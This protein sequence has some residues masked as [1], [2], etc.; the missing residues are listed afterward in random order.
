[1]KLAYMRKKANIYL[2]SGHVVVVQISSSFCVVI[3]TIVQNVKK[4]ISLL[5]M[6]TKKILHDDF[7]LLLEYIVVKLES[8]SEKKIL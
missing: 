4:L 1:M 3:S 5:A 7:L 2:A 8:D 6:S